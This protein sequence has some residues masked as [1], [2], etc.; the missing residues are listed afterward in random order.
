MPGSQ[1]LFPI[2]FKIYTNLYAIMISMTERRIRPLK[3]C[4]VCQCIVDEASECPICGNTITYEPH[5]M[6]DKEHFAFNRY[7][8]TYLLKNLWFPVLCTIASI[9][10]FILTLPLTVPLAYLLLIPTAFLLIMSFVF[11]LFKRPLARRMLWKY[12]E[13]Y[14]IGRINNDK[15]FFGFGA[16][17]LLIIVGYLI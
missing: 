8:K 12:S 16:V 7:Y 17:L 15:Y 2:L 9:I 1:E 3:K 14:A 4:N 10:I 6:E 5:C 11:A 13:E